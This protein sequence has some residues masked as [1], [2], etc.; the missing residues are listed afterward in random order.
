[1][2]LRVFFFPENFSD[3]RF[4]LDGLLSRRFISQSEIPTNSTI[5]MTSFSAQL[6]YAVYYWWYHRRQMGGKGQTII[7]HLDVLKSARLSLAQSSPDLYWRLTMEFGRIFLFYRDKKHR[8]FG[9]RHS[10]LR[11]GRGRGATKSRAD[12]L[13][14]RVRMGKTSSPN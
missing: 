12:P 8:F 10:D 5:L 2:V 1:M 11:P 6:V 4:L 9:M 13:I 3:S 7:V 14:L